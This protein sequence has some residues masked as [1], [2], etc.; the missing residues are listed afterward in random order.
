M[1]GNLLKKHYPEVKRKP[2]APETDVVKL[3]NVSKMF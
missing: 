1:L 2:S 3:E